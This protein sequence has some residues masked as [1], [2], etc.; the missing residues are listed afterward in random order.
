MPNSSTRWCGSSYGRPGVVPS[1][2]CPRIS[3]SLRRVRESAGR[4]RGL[5]RQMV[6]AINSLQSA[7]SPLFGQAAGDPPTSWSPFGGRWKAPRA[8]PL[9]E[10]GLQRMVDPDILE[11][12]RQENRVLLT[13]D[14]TRLGVSTSGSQGAPQ[15]G[16]VSS[17][18]AGERSWS[19]YAQK[20]TGGRKASNR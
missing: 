15:Q 11:K 8:E 16:Q 12:A 5:S 18:G 20:R 19:Q 6:T 17:A 10:E 13:T 3:S 1:P 9:R 7:Y 14:L 2:W 4:V